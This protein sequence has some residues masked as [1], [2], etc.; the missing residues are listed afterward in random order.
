MGKIVQTRVVSGIYKRTRDDVP[1]PKPYLVRYRTHPTA[2]PRGKSFHTLSEAKRFQIDTKASVLTGHFIDPTERM[3]TVRQYGERWA[4][5]KRWAKATRTRKES[6]LRRHIYPHF[7]GLMADV[8][9]I[10][11]QSWVNMMEDAYGAKTV[12]LHYDTLA[13]LFNDAVED[14]KLVASPCGRRI[15]RPKANQQVDAVLAPAEVAAIAAGMDDAYELIVWL[16]AMAGL[17]ISEALGLT[18][19]HVD[20]EKHTISVKRQWLPLNKFGPPK[21]EH[22]DRVIPVHP[23]LIDRITAHVAAHGV[24][25]KGTLFR[26]GTAPLR[27]LTF[28]NVVWPAAVDGLVVAEGCRTFHALR[29]HYASTLIESTRNA[30]I[31]QKR[32][33]HS[34]IQVTFD[35]YGHLFPGADEDTRGAFEGRYDTT[36]RVAS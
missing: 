25:D 17:R 32:L 24:S 34:S 31:V 28:Y 27:H 33:G 18:M 1:L 30:K 29:H 6:I 9:R 19:A 2:N 22:S 4:A 23:D 12:R 13:S 20:V 21:T 26:E 7:D 8:D 3:L 5:A 14:G 36:L 11:V 15:E 16:G 10:A 35:T